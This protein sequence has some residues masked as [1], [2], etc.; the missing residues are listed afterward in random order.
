[1]TRPLARVLIDALADHGAH[2]VFGIPG[3]FALPFFRH[4]ERAADRLPLYTLAHEPGVG[5]AADA[6]ARW[7]A[8]LG[9]ACVT[10]GAGALNMVNPIAG[11]F[12]EKSPVV[13]ISGAPGVNESAR[14][15]LLHHQA[16]TLD[17]QLRVYREITCDQAVLDDPQRAPAEIARVL[18]SCR[19]QSRPVYIEIPRDQVDVPCAPVDPLPP[20]PVE[21]AAVDACAD[22]VLARLDRADRPVLLVGVEVRRF[23]LEAR[24]A[25]LAT[26]LGIPVATTFMGR[27][28]LAESAAPLVGTYMGLAGR[29]EVRTVVEESDGLLMLGVLMSDTNFGVSGERVDPRATMLAADRS[30]RVGFHVY[31][32]VPLADLIDALLARAP[33]PGA[34]RAAPVL[35]AQPDPPRGLIADDAPVHPR[36]IAAGVNDLF[37]ETGPMPVAADMGDCLFTA[38]DMVQTPLVAPGYY[39]TMGFGVPAGMGVA[40]ASGRRPLILVGDGAFQMTG[41]ELAT[42]ARHGWAPI[43][44]VFNNASWEMLRT[45]QPEGRYNDL[46]VLPFARLAAGLGGRGYSVSTRA[47]LAA[48]LRE[49]RADTSRFQLL[50]V[51]IARGEISDTLARFVAAIKQANRPLGTR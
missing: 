32:G 48:A 14:G 50:D 11:A 51:A 30:V 27:G 9:V 21:A 40:A 16:K 35:P 42:C 44:V 10:Y 17:S 6:A 36:D 41:W 34:G 8:G 39:A 22:E 23:G 38:M 28:L 1:M 43:V 3:D 13:V 29:P 18:R 7:H 15:L 5:F 37:A 20:T 19:E 2:E 49:A 12:S 31:P 46:D 33:G 47:E 4:L 24:V 45:F 26:R 25:D